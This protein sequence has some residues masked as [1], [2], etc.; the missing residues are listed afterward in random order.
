MNEQDKHIYHRE[1]AQLVVESPVNIPKSNRG[2]P[3]IIFLALLLSVLLFGSFIAWYREYSVT[4]AS[5]IFRFFVWT[6]VV[7]DVFLLITRALREW[8]NNR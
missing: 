7:S 2:N 8:A 6:L 4:N 5:L 3:Y 1:V